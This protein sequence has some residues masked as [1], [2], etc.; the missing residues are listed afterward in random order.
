VSTQ[1]AVVALM[2]DQLGKTLKNFFQQG[3][4][5]NPL[6]LI[7]INSADRTLL[8]QLEEVEN[9]EDENKPPKITLSLII[10]ETV[11]PSVLS[12][13]QG[14]EAHA[15]PISLPLLLPNDLLNRLQ[16]L[17]SQHLQFFQ[18]KIVAIRNL[19]TARDSVTIQNAAQDLFELPQLW[20]TLRPFIG[21]D[22]GAVLSLATIGNALPNPAQIVAPV[23]QAVLDYFFKKEG[24]QTIDGASVVAP[25][26][27]SDITNS[28]TGQIAGV[29]G[30]AGLDQLKHLFSKA[31]AEHYLRDTIRVTVE[32][33]Y[34][35]ARNLGNKYNSTKDGVKNRKSDP[36]RKEAIGRKFVNWFR[37]FSSVAESASM[38]A[39]EVATQGVSEFQTNPLIAA[40]AGSF[41]GTVA[42][43][44]AQDSF[45]RVLRRD[46]GLP[47]S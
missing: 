28:A 40:A 42:R 47:L 19:V 30:S 1:N 34:D 26:H 18:G 25:V 20:N 35:T 38:R 23:E 7:G 10:G 46:L 15:L 14:L 27:L 41:A 24:Y 39:V 8:L 5:G 16:D 45:L 32:A 43:K 9:P 31:T 22:I 6:D 11:G 2:H 21:N 13:L 17:L 36:A 12:L 44:I 33:A 29:G 4:G 3:T 37:G